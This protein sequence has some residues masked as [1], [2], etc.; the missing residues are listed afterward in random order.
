[1][2]VTRSLNVTDRYPF[3]YA[4]VIQKIQE[5]VAQAKQCHVNDFIKKNSVKGNQKYCGY[6]YRSKRDEARGPR[7]GTA[8]CYNRDLIDYAIVEIKKLTGVQQTLAAT[9]V[10]LPS[11]PGQP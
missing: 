6:S 3:T 9:G 2:I 4:E 8:C 7:P 10:I 11:A 5:S 1:V